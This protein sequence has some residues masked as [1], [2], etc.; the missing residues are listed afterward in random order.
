G[1]RGLVVD[2]AVVVEE[3]EA[4]VAL[5][6]VAVDVDV[7]GEGLADLRRGAMPG[8][9]AAEQ[10]IAALALVEEIGAEPADE[11]EVG[12]AALDHQAG[13]HAAALQIPGVGAHVGLGPDGA[14]L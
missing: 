7:V 10:A 9:L 6:R 1:E 13:G 2:A 3:E 8:G 4:D 11:E 14:G 12:L 5:A